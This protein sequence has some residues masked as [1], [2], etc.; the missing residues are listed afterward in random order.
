MENAI[1]VSGMFLGVI[2]YWLIA[3]S[4]VMPALGKL[5]RA[6]AL[7]PLLFLHCFRYIG[8]AFLLPGVVAAD[9]STTFAVTAA[10]GDLA[11]ALLALVAVIALRN[12]WGMA[13][14][15]VWIFNVVGTLDLLHALPQG[16]LH[17][18]AGQLGGAYLIPALIVPALLVSHYLVFKL[19]R[20][21]SAG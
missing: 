14:G 12:Q 21:R 17:I 8:M 2:A 10:Y 15:L 5:P 20:Q 13:I 6:E 9:L 4:Y 11:A 1:L 18:H 3:R 16:V 19:L 7:Q